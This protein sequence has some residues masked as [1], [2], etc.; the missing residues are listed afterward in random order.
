MARQYKRTYSL[1]IT[2]EEG[3][4]RIITDLRI[5]F[6]IT[7]SVISFP[8]LAKITIYNPNQETIS[9][10]QRRYTFISL[11]AGYENNSSLIFM[12][13]IRNVFHSKPSV[14]RFVT[15]YAGDGERSWQNAMINRTLGQNITV[16]TAIN[17]LLE[18]FEGL[19]IGSVRGLPD[20]ADRLRGQTLSGSSKN[21]LDDFAREYGFDWSIQDNEL[22]VNPVDSV[23]E[24]STSILVSASTG[25]VGTPII[26]EIGA[27]VTTLLNPDMLPNRSFTIESVSSE[28]QLGNLFFR[29]VPRTSAE[30][31][32][33][34][35]ET[36]FKGDSR[37]GDWLSLSKGRII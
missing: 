17:T 25:M 3:N 18:S 27:D 32:Y 6:E 14:D 15:I 36:T 34:I 30:G 24:D 9:L 22:I 20:V 5:D 35:I 33:K 29:Q 23:L 19:S 12:G 2:P 16:T 11:N 8:N 4:S 21:I 10:L 28:T 31:V 37:E 1:T 13:E 7:K 26:T